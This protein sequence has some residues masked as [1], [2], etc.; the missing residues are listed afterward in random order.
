[1]KRIIVFL[2]SFI[3]IISSFTFYVAAADSNTITTRIFNDR[4]VSGAP[5]FTDSITFDEVYAGFNEEYNLNLTSADNSYIL[6]EFVS[7][8]R[9]AQ[10]DITDYI[11][12][13]I[14]YSFM[15]SSGTQTYRY[16]IRKIGSIIY[17]SNA[18]TI[19]TVYD[20]FNAQ[21]Y[22]FGDYIYYNLNFIDLSGYSY[23]DVGFIGANVDVDNFGDTIF[24]VIDT[25][26]DVIVS[27]VVS[28]REVYNSINTGDSTEISFLSY[29][30]NINDYHKTSLLYYNNDFSKYDFIP[31]IPDFYYELLNAYSFNGGNKVYF[32]INDIIYI[33]SDINFYNTYTIDLYVG[34]EYFEK[35]GSIGMNLYNYNGTTVYGSKVIRG[36]YIDYSVK[37]KKTVDSVDF[38]L[39][40]EGASEYFIYTISYDLIENIE[41]LGLSFTKNNP[42]PDI[43]FDVNF[44]SDTVVLYEGKF[45]PPGTFDNLNFYIV[46]ASEFE[47]IKEEVSKEFLDESKKQNAQLT[48]ST[49]QLSDKMQE[50]KDVGTD[51]T[52][53]VINNLKVVMNGEGATEGKEIL[54]VLFDIPLVIELMIISLSMALLGYV[55]FG[56]KG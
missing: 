2:I 22:N 45:I 26:G 20:G 33:E 35:L 12:F 7:F 55:L 48:N 40:I 8:S 11:H 47:V 13:D 17:I 5:L 52:T 9:M 28:H 16:V 39:N 54:N 3:L 32:D 49:A 29:R 38:Y 19:D 44:D 36:S 56:K 6:L 4:S 14:M 27:E 31:N 34:G 43:S 25:D 18:N 46:E 23:I 41:Y 21:D 10:D 24:R 50:F 42:Y 51:T 30:I 37:I 53:N 1:M 15:Y